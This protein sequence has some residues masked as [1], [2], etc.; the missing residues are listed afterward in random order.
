M[1]RPAPHAPWDGDGRLLV[2]LYVHP[3]THPEEWAAL[4]AAAPGLHA[5]VL[6]VADGPGSSCDPAFRDVARRLR[7]AGV[8]LL[9]YVDTGYG[10]RPPRAVAADVLRHRRWYGVDGV[11]FDQAAADAAA[12]PRYRGLATAA[13]LLGARCVVLNPGTHPAPGYAAL[14]DLLVTFEGTWEAYRR[15]GVPA[16]TADHPPGRFCHLVHAVPPDRTAQV[17]RT[18]AAR[19]AGVHCAVPGTGANPWC[20]VP[21]A[22][23]RAVGSTR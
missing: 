19:G 11:F 3:A 7:R 9:G 2:P 12:L 20:S 14:A 6:N 21:R 4:V 22:G 13:R 5:V 18:A 1:K 8:R 15:A 23:E 17:A 16:W 10:R